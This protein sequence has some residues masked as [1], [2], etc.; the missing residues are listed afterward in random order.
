MSK[1][2]ASTDRIKIFCGLGNNGGDGLAIARLLA[3]KDFR[4]E[5]FVLRY[6][7]KSSEDFD[8][9]LENLKYQKKVRINEINTFEDL[10][11]SLDAEWIVDAIFGSGLSKPVTGFIAEVIGFLN[12]QKANIA[13]IDIPSGLFADKST[14]DSGGAIIHADITLTFESA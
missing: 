7:D 5:V 10:P 9:N 11:A 1:N 13:A 12:K 6:S 2:F 8:I 3:K 14:V 4:V